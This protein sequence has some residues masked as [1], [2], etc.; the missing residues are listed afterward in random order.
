M[1]TFFKKIYFILQDFRAPTM[2]CAVNV[3]IIIA[4]KNTEYTVYCI[5]LRQSQSNLVI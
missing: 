3:K 4:T 5:I 1:L 2:Q